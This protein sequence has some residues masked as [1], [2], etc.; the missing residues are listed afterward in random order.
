[1]NEIVVAFVTY[2]TEWAGA[3]N[4]GPVPTD[5]WNFDLPAKPVH[6]AANK[7]EPG[8]IALLLGTKEELESKT[9][10][11][12]RSAIS[13]FRGNNIVQAQFAQ[14]S[15]CRGGGSDSW[16]YNRVGPGDNVAV[17][18]YGDNSAGSLQRAPD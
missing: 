7:P 12:K 4:L 8:R 13:H 2:L 16:E 15:H 1:M 10:T 5:V 3:N 18:R 9:N 14:A 17:A 11:E 6:A